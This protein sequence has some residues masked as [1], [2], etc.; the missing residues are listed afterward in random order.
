MM[1]GLAARQSVV[2]LKTLCVVLCVVGIK[3]NQETRQTPR[4]MPYKDGLREA[5][6]GQEASPAKGRNHRGPPD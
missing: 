5:E 4:F 3:S 1:S 6:V 2:L